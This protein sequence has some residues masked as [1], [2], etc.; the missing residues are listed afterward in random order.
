MSEILCPREH[1]RGVNVWYPL[2]IGVF[3]LLD[4]VWQ[5]YYIVCL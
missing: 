1:V 4:L 3:G 2:N 5:P